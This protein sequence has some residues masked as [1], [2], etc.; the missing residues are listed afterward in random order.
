VNESTKLQKVDCIVSL[1][2]VTEWVRLLSMG[3]E[4]VVVFSKDEEVMRQRALEE[5]MR[6]CEKVRDDM[7][8]IWPDLA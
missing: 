5:A 8:T 2:T 1:D 7:V 4:P 6:A 3:A